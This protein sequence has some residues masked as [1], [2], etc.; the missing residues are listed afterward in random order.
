MNRKELVCIRCPLGC[1]M[2]VVMDDGDIREIKGNTCKRG[3]DYARREITNP[4][5]TVTSTVRVAGIDDMMIPVKTKKDIPKEKMMDCVKA[6][7]DIKV[8][9]PVHLGDVIIEN[10]V[11]TGVSI[12][13]ARTVEKP[14]TSCKLR[15]NTIQ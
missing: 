13:A 2:E 6:L 10:V 1:N 7:K 8:T 9:L 5:R 3:E 12:I 14:T 4:V 11:E 15:A